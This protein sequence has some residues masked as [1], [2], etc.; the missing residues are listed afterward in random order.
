MTGE[1]IVAGGGR[2][3]NMFIGETRGYVNPE[4]T[5]E[6]LLDNFERVQD[7]DGYEALANADA[8]AAFCAQIV[9]HP[10]PGA[11]K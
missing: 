10:L 2:V 5:M 8:A 6:S 1:V 9:E 3:A 4:L 7:R 11:K